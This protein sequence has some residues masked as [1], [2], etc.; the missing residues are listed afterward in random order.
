MRKIRKLER[1]EHK[2]KRLSLLRE[3]FCGLA[4]FRSKKTKMKIIKPQLKDAEIETMAIAFFLLLAEN[5]LF[6]SPSSTLFLFF[7][8]LFAS[9]ITAIFAFCSVLIDLSFHPVAVASNP[10]KYSN[11]GRGTERPK[12]W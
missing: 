4:P 12:A 8:A 10:L 7:F 11:T 2:N 9:I 6:L 5:T 3:V 1:E